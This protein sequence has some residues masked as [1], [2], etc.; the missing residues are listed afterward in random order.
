MPRSYLNKKLICIQE[1]LASL[2]IRSIFCF[3]VKTLRWR[4]TIPA[5]P[6]Q[7]F[8]QMKN[9][10][11]PARTSRTSARERMC[12][13]KFRALSR[14]RNRTTV[15]GLTKMR[16]CFQRARSFAQKSRRAYRVLP[17]WA[18]DVFVSVPP[19]A[20]EGLGFPGGVFDELLTQ[21]WPVIH[22]RNLSLRRYLTSDLLIFGP[23]SRCTIYATFGIRLYHCVA[24][25]YANAS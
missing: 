9:R 24:C 13:Q 3:F 7:N 6:R 17:A 4:K 16:A 2:L 10:L 20:G 18:S 23:R 1:R 25:S 8:L 22:F 11:R 19:V 14:R 5:A 12:A 15:S 21:P